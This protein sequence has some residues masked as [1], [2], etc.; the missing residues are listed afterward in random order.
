M[1]KDVKTMHYTLT[2]S[3]ESGIIQVV[4]GYAICPKCGKKKLARVTPE[5]EVSAAGLWCRICGEVNISITP[6]R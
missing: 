5:T 4:N 6:E 2:D 3:G 1:D